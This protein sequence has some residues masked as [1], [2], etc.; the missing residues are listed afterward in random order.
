MSWLK[1]NRKNFFNSLKYKKKILIYHFTHL[2]Y[3]INGLHDIKNIFPAVRKVLDKHMSLKNRWFM[4]VY[5]LKTQTQALKRCY[6]PKMM[7]ALLF[8]GYATGIFSSRAL[9]QATY[10]L[11]PVI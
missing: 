9:E 7:L 3:K 6:P 11:I 8:Y 4:H 1:I 5:L 2:Y 10:E